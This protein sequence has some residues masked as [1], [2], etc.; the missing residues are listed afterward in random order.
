MQ[1][2][3]NQ[4]YT[5][6]EVVVNIGSGE[7]TGS[8]YYTKYWVVVGDEVRWDFHL[9]AINS[10]VAKRYELEDIKGVYRVVSISEVATGLEIAVQ[11]ADLVYSQ[12]EVGEPNPKFN[13]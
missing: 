9:A 10:V 3:K 6:Y 7:E 2:Y 1:V 12:Y 11:Q 4:Y 8:Q 5:R 13:K